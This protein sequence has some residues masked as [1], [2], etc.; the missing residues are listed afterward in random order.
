M[1]L[2]NIFLLIHCFTFDTVAVESANFSMLLHV[3]AIS[4]NYYTCST[5][6]TSALFIHEND[7]KLVLVCS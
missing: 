1:N 3:V 4:D 5:L 6:Y 2:L 7:A